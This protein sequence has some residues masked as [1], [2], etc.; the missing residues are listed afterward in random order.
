CKI[1]QEGPVVLMPLDATN[2]SLYCLTFY[3][4]YIHKQENKVHV[5]YVAEDYRSRSTTSATEVHVGQGPTKTSK[6]GCGDGCFS[7]VKSLFNRMTIM[8]SMGPSPGI[9]KELEREDKA[10]CRSIRTKVREIFTAN[11]IKNWD[12]KRLTGENPWTAILEY[13]E[14]IG[15]TMIVLGSRELGMLKRKIF[16]SVSE[17]VL[18]NS[19]VP[20][21]I[22]RLPHGALRATTDT[23][24][25]SSAID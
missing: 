13:R 16:G 10:S 22:V 12:F 19:T 24:T 2:H 4:K 15:G 8:E 25:G 5:C 18:H 17:K 20:V 7:C 21:L 3:V 11:E 23:A 1:L 6:P 9:I 14:E